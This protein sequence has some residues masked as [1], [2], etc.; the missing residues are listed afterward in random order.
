[1]FNESLPV[2][3][4]PPYKM[5]PELLPQTD[6]KPLIV[7]SLRVVNCG[8]PIKLE[9]TSSGEKWT[10]RQPVSPR[11]PVTMV[12]DFINIVLLL[13]L[14]YFTVLKLSSKT[15]SKTLK[16]KPIILQLIAKCL[17]FLYITN[18]SNCPKTYHKAVHSDITWTLNRIFGHSS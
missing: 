3:G 16:I 15:S 8:A 14:L 1:M 5:L 18:L 7:P 6:Y 2:A 17:I 11:T 9:L 12:T 10:G 4:L 13:Q